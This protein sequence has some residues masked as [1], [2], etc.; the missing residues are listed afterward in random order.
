MLAIPQLR[1]VDLRDFPLQLFRVLG[2]ELELG[3]VALRVLPRIVVPDLSWGGTEA[4]S[5]RARPHPAA[6]PGPAVPDARRG[7]GAQSPQCQGSRGMPHCH[8]RVSHREG[9]FVRH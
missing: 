4:M 8:G 3:A 6:T 7:A 1:L 5:G 2:E 9:S